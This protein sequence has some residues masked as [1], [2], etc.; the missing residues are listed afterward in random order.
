MFYLLASEGDVFCCFVMRLHACAI[1][2][3][4]GNFTLSMCLGLKYRC[5]LCSAQSRRS[6]KSREEGTHCGAGP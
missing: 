4:A 3:K 2:V 5:W 1:F 6:R